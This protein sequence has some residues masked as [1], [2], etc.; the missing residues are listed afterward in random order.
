MALVGGDAVGEAGHHHDTEQQH[1]FVQHA[2]EAAAQARRPH[3]SRLSWR[4]ARG[5]GLLVGAEADERTPALWVPRWGSSVLRSTNPGV[6]A[7]FGIPACW[8]AGGAG[9]RVTSVVVAPGAAC[10][11]VG[12]TGLTGVAE[13]DGLATMLRLVD[14]SGGPLALPS[15][16]LAAARSANALRSL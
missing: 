3:H 11:T 16:A 7:I 6:A 2:R 4:H 13:S 10:T 12:A 15:W 1:R 14:S 9:W 8:C 5:H